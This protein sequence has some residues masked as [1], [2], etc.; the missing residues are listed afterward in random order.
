MARQTGTPG[1]LRPPGG[2]ALGPFWDP[3]LSAAIRRYPRS[4][5]GRNGPLSALGP[6]SGPFWYGSQDHAGNRAIP[7]NPFSKPFRKRFGVYGNVRVSEAGSLFMVDR[8]D[9]EGTLEAQFRPCNWVARD[10]P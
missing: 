1:T 7:R 8:F 3:P 4:P 10:T 9:A 6:L 5:G 2:D